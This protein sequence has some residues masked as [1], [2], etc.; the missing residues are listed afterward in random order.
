[1]TAAKLLLP[2]KT[3]DAIPVLCITAPNWAEASHALEPAEATAAE[4]QGFK[5]QSGRCL[6]LTG[7]DGKLSRVL[8][9]LGEKKSG[10]DA[11]LP[12]KLA[13]LLPQGSY[14]LEGEVASFRL[15]ALAWLL[16]AYVFARYKK[17]QGEAAA[18]L[19]PQE[20]DRDHIIVQA[21]AVWLARDLINTP[22]CDMG[23]GELEQAAKDLA[24][25][26]KANMRTII[27]K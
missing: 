22:A 14:R 13:R 26:H 25:K 5:A 10:D 3:P 27:G 1:M 8:F 20:E 23:P 6:P 11:F 24:A 16:E 12:G 18:L 9:G 21:D 7:R 15:A 17:P 19:C 2:A 4:T